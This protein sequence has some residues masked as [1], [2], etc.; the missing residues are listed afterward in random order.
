MAEETNDIRQ[1]VQA[2]VQEFVK[3]EHHRAE[4]AYKAEL[5]DEKRR[6][7]RVF[8]TFQQH[9]ATFGEDRAQFNGKIAPEKRQRRETEVDAGH[10]FLWRLRELTGA[11][12]TGANR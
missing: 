1:L 8:R 9:V 4:P 10:T 3:A 5:Q 12:D 11:F 2:V 6:L 7:G